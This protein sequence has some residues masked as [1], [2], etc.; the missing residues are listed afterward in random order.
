MSINAK[1]LFYRMCNACKKKVERALER[2]PECDKDDFVYKFN[3]PMEF[4]DQTGSLN[5]VGFDPACQQLFSKF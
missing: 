1:W 4:S 5:C 3:C 2:C